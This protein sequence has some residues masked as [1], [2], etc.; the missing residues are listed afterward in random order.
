M[1]VTRCAQV[2][3][4]QLIQACSYSA[5]YKYQTNLLIGNLLNQ[6]CK[7]KLFV[8]FSNLIKLIDYCY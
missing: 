4:E 1:E 5:K 2:C 6:V 7:H 8:F 3:I